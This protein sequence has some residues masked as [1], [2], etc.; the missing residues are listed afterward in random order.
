[1]T[2]INQSGTISSMRRSRIT[3][4]LK[5]QLVTDLD[6]LVDGEKIRNRSHAIEYIV[7]RFFQPTIKKAVIM[8][9]GR[10]TEISPSVIE[11]QIANL[12]KS[13]IDEIVICT[14]VSGDKIRRYF[15]TGEKFG[16]RINY[17]GEKKP[18]QTGGAL[19]K[20]KNFLDN[21]PFLVIYGDVITNLPFIDVVNFHEQQKA[22]ATIALTTVEKPE[23]F[24]QLKLHGITLVNFYQKNKTQP[25][26]S[27][28]I[29]C[30]IYVFQPE[31]FDYFP[32]REKPFLLEDIIE[33]L[34]QKK[35]V[36]GF[37]FEE[38]WIDVGKT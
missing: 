28:L 23:E 1:M 29:N 37:V 5:Q 15:G 20:T 13:H 35:K 36:N 25:V 14:G 32:H 10:G 3:I 8:A 2:I 22:L 34:I 38:K 17:S 19:L 11:S 18:L 31:I 26:K 4:T 24:G 7:D 12:K 6:Q 27:N 16:V 9:G 33:L 21:K 30:G